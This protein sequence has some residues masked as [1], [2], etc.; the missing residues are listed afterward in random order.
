M[1]KKGRTIRQNLAVL[2]DGFRRDVKWELPLRAALL[3]MNTLGYLDSEQMHDLKTLANMTIGTGAKGHYLVH[4]D[5]L[6]RLIGQVND[7]NGEVSDSLAV[8]IEAS[9]LVL[10]EY[11]KT[12]KNVAIARVAMKGVKNG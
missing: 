11:I 8:G 4:A 6:D 12:V 9:C 2:P 3:S 7:A 10:L 5:S 1:R